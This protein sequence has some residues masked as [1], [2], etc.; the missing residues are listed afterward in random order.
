MARSLDEPIPEPQF[1]EGF[2]LRPLAGEGEVAAYVALHRAAF[3]TENMT[4]ERRLAIVRN[5]GYIPELDLV[6]AAPD[7]TLAAFCVCSV[8]AE[9]NATRELPRGAIDIIGSRPDWRGKGLGRAMLLA[10]LRALRA[11][12]MGVATLGTGSDNIA[13]Q[14]LYES[15]GFRVA[16]RKRWYTK[17]VMA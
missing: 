16:Y 6:A 7:G 3:G 8:E 14:R 10:G 5:Q 1:P 13:G 17:S 15:A 12:G 9:E 4:V 2:V 11:H